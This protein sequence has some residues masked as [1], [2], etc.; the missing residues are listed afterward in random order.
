MGYANEHFFIAGIG[1]GWYEN[2]AA[3]CKVVIRKP[4]SVR[5]L[6]ASFKGSI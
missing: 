2:I 3:V 4:G 1:A 6:P 5:A